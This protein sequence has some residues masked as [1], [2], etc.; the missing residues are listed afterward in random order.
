M[1][2]LP[3]QLNVFFESSKATYNIAKLSRNLK[4]AIKTIK[5]AEIMDSE[6]YFHPLLPFPIYLPVDHQIPGIFRWLRAILL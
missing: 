5:C 6:Q 3:Q 1:P 4:G 2:G